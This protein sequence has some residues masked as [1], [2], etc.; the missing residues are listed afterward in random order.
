MQNIWLLVD[1]LRL[2]PCWWSPVIS[3]AYEI[4]L[5]GSMLHGGR[6]NFGRLVAGIAGSNPAKGMDVYFCVYILCCL[7]S[8][9]AFTTS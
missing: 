2:N 4:N 1:G 8:V 3:F 5:E 7:V 9:E 6:V